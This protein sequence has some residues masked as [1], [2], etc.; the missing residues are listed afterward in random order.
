M[1]M[2]I[3]QRQRDDR[4]RTQQ[5]EQGIP[6]PTKVV[7]AARAARRRRA[8]A[9]KAGDSLV[10]AQRLLLTP[11]S[12]ASSRR[13]ASSSRSSR[14]SGR[15]SGTR[16]SSTVYS[17]ISSNG[18]SARF[19]MSLDMS[20]VTMPPRP[21]VRW[22]V[23]GF[24]RAVG[25]ASL[26]GS[27]AAGAPGRGDRRGNGS[28]SSSGGGERSHGTH[29][30][31]LTSWSSS[32]AYPEAYDSN[33]VARKRFEGAV[34]WAQARERART[35]RGRR[36]AASAISAYYR[37][38]RRR[39][40]CDANAKV[41]QRAFRR[42]ALYHYLGT[43][44]L[45]L[46]EKRV[47]SEH[48]RRNFRAGLRWTDAEKGVMVALEIFHGVPNYHDDW[49]LRASYLSSQDQIDEARA[50]KQQ[51]DEGD[52]ESTSRRSTGTAT[53]PSS[54]TGAGNER[55][56]SSGSTPARENRGPEFFDRMRVL[57]PGAPKSIKNIQLKWKEMHA[58]RQL[59]DL[60]G[61]VV[62]KG[63]VWGW[64]MAVPPEV[65]SHILPPW[66]PS[67][68]F[69]AAAP[70]GAIAASLSLGNA[71]RGGVPVDLMSL[72]VLAAA[73]QKG[74]GAPGSEV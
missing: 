46:A 59:G 74:T 45:H 23:G 50:M 14:R 31:D 26:G 57:T 24:A 22:V 56:A 54:S 19:A 73:R 55:T 71:W 42:R 11:M 30:S 13:F 21:T 2:F 9:K 64:L 32:E 37:A 51:H 69:P 67:G 16:R 58:A 6:P 7:E 1:Q 18:A 4:D 68:S 44:R 66:C 29:D 49:L 70:Q 65:L 5:E 3:Q 27:G 20:G 10:A 34:S 47:A 41:I 8:K 40:V 15:S 25:L 35:R 60:R 28:S 39:L 33:P 12:T 61:G 43:H 63:E 38:Y 62:L 72:P 52:D 48:A 17:S 53:E 36:A